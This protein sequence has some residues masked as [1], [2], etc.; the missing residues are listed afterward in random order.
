MRHWSNA[1]L[2]SLGASVHHLI[3][4]AIVTLTCVLLMQAHSDAQALP[5][6]IS[7]PEDVDIIVSPGVV[8]ELPVRVAA[9]FGAMGGVVE[10][11]LDN[12][13]PW[14]TLEDLTEDAFGASAR[15]VITRTGA[16]MPPASLGIRA[17]YVVG[18]VVESEIVAT[19]T[20]Q[21]P[22]GAAL[23]GLELPEDR[24]DVVAGEDYF[25]RW[26]VT[27]RALADASGAAYDAYERVDRADPGCAW[28][29]GP[30]ELVTS[31]SVGGTYAHLWSGSP[32]VPGERCRVALGYRRGELGEWVVRV[33]ELVTVA[34]S[35]MDGPPDMGAVGDMDV[36]PA[37]TDMGGQEDMAGPMERELVD[38]SDGCGCDEDDGGQPAPA[39]LVVLGLGAMRLR[40]GVRR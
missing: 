30:T 15:L 40:R 2:L 37:P 39:L 32:A 5:P 35:A 20:V 13:V 29:V 22:V 34:D 6:I 33:T 9:P 17:R 11:G 28:V 7:V 36:T 16:G 23:D 27:D 18:G 4:W 1:T 3:V 26:G 38:L 8:G 10:L 12:P 21:R 14:V 31:G 24:T 19:V 25:A